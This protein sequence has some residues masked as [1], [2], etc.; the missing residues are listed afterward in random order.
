MRAGR[1]SRILIVGII[2]AA[3]CLVAVGAGIA[4]TTNTDPTGDATGGAPDIT[5]VVASNNAAG[6]ITFRVT[7]VA[8]MIDSSIMGI[9]LDTDSNPGTGGGGFEYGL[10]AGAGGFGLL[11]WTGN[12]FADA[13]ARSLSMIRSGNVV[14]FKINR[15]D[16]GKIDRFSF[17]VYTVNFDDSDAAIGEDGAPDGGAYVY[18]LSLPQCANGKDDDG[19]GRIDR[20]DFGCSSP[21]DKLERDDRVTLKANKALT[22]P[23]KPTA[24]RAVVVGAVVIR[25]ETGVG[26]TS[27]NVRCAARVGSKALPGTGKVRQ[28]VAACTLALPATSKGELVRGTITITVQ[29]HSIKVPFVFKVN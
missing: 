22:V 7:T 26:I 9:D 25:G 12:A 20:R 10:I 13:P 8:P 1:K 15:A 19:D 2:A 24:G 21:S 29:G 16:I 11:K 4:D 17:D 6:V 5:R 27:G 23:A 14:V 18:A 3:A 28:G